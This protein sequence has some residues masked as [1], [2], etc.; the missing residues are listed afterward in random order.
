VSY[1]VPVPPPPRPVP[2]FRPRSHTQVVERGELDAQPDDAGDAPHRPRRGAPRAACGTPSGAPIGV[3]P[4][5]V[6]LEFIGRRP[7]RPLEVVWQ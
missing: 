1:L 2:R 6:P 4:G 5:A 3:S 7:R